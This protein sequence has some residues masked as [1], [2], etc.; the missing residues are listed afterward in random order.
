MLSP[1]HPSGYTRS[2]AGAKHELQWSIQWDTPKLD[3]AGATTREKFWVP[4]HDR[5]TQFLK[6]ELLSNNVLQAV[7]ELWSSELSI[8]M[9]GPFSTLSADLQSVWGVKTGGKRLRDWEQ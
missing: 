8:Q 9:G 7:G 1:R 3:W 5:L 6:F 2:A 4:S